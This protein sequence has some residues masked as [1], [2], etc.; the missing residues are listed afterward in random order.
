MTMIQG[1]LTP[2]VKEGSIYE[3]DFEAMSYSE[4]LR[5]R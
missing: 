1:E 4:I 3:G 5:Y 2:F